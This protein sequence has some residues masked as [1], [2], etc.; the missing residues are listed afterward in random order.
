M[1]LNLAI[2]LGTRRGG[3]FRKRDGSDAQAWNGVLFRKC[4]YSRIG[5]DFFF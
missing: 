4:R 1:G 2:E 3:S 5:F